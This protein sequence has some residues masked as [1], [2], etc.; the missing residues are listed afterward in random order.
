MAR[1]EASNARRRLGRQ[2][3]AVARQVLYTFI[4]Q[5]LFV[6]LDPLY[7]NVLYALSRLSRQL[8]ASMRLKLPCQCGIH[9]TTDTST[10]L[11]IH[12]HNHGSRLRHFLPREIRASFG[13]PWIH[14]SSLDAVALRCAPGALWKFSSYC[15]EAGHFGPTIGKCRHRETILE[16]LGFSQYNRSRMVSE[17]RPDQE[18][19][20]NLSAPHTYAYRACSSFDRLALTADFQQS[21]DI[22]QIPGH[23]IQYPEHF[24]TSVAEDR[25]APL[26]TV[27]QPDILPGRLVLQ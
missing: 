7:W 16:L 23:L 19:W 4:Q 11:R 21:P 27:R 18:Q 12:M 3:V 14:L 10:A 25:I 1:T 5:G 9:S 17:D 22:R 24:A 8:F 2:R 15:S 26:R 20:D 13:T 6:A